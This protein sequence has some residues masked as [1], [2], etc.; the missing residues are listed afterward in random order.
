MLGF[1]LP[2]CLVFILYFCQWFSNVC[3][4]VSSLLYFWISCPEN[5]HR[6]DTLTYRSNNFRNTCAFIVGVL[7]W[8]VFKVF[9]F[10]GHTNFEDGCK[11][12]F[13]NGV[14]HLDFLRTCGS[15]FYLQDCPSMLTTPEHSNI[16]KL[17]WAQS[18]TVYRTDNGWGQC[19]T[20]N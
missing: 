15:L 20:K 10:L 1:V 19:Q 6:R 4:I 13:Y 5:R 16:Y 17:Q 14:S 18:T 7:F 12:Q 3:Y 2:K 8:N 11:W 9:R